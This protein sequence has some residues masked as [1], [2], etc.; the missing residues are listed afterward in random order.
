MRKYFVV[1][2]RKAVFSPF[3]LWVD[4]VK[5]DNF[6]LLINSFSVYV[7]KYIM[8]EIPFKIVYYSSDRIHF[9]CFRKHCIE[10]TCMYNLSTLENHRIVVE[11]LCQKYCI[12]SRS[13]CNLV[14]F[15]KLL[16]NNN[17]YITL[18]NMEFDNPLKY[19][20]SDIYYF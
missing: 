20:H 13:M 16:T 2:R 5:E 7:L 8:N 17:Q 18:L 15:W 6:C 3:D 4:Y 12:S 9:D 10:N 14:R 1:L 19:V 11:I